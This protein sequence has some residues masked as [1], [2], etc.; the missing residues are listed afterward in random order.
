MISCSLGLCVSSGWSHGCISSTDVVGRD[1][2]GEGP[3][4]LPS[5]ASQGTALAQR[6]ECRWQ[7]LS[8]IAGAWRR[9]CECLTRWYPL[10][11][12]EQG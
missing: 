10:I 1:A 4:T 3:I 7:S 2:G 11:P 6:G 5:T 9:S 12:S 8:S